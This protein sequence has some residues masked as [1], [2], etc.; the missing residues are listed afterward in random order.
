VKEN[1]RNDKLHYEDRRGQN[2]RSAFKVHS[3]A[4]QIIINVVPGVDVDLSCKRTI[5]ALR[6]FAETIEVPED[7]KS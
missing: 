3:T 7:K 1:V 4:N 2:G 5:A 6:A